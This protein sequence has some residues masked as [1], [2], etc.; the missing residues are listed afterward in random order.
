MNKVFYNKK[1]DFAFFLEVISNRKEFNKEI[2]YRKKNSPYLM[3][4]NEVLDYINFINSF[5][6][7]LSYIEKGF[8]N[9]YFHNSTIFSS[10][11]IYIFFRKL[12]FDEIAFTTFISFIN[13]YYHTTLTGDLS[14]QKIEE[15][16]KKK[17][18][19]I[20]SKDDIN[21][22]AD[23]IIS[24]FR[25]DD[26]IKIFS[27]N[28][29]KLYDKFARILLQ[30]SDDIKAKIENIKSIFIKEYNDYLKYL[31]NFF[32]VDN[33]E[34]YRLVYSYFCPYQKSILERYRCIVI[35]DSINNAKS[36]NLENS[37]ILLNKF[38]SQEK[39]YKII[40]MLSD[41]KYFSTE[42]AKELKITTATMNYHIN[43]LYDL[44]LINIEEG[45]KNRLY[46]DLNK[47]RLCYLLDGMRKDLNI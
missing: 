27:T 37:Y 5:Y 18:I 8:L 6:N 47:N 28:I 7:D 24:I 15:I 3:N 12:S 44:G 41:K 9:T 42:L 43:K 35:G 11:L 16:V 21:K 32:N 22:N 31:N 29:K 34:S 30:Y 36:E 26:N 13:D 2:T 38:L 33:I 14:N 25:D 45:E 1:I 17:S 23:L 19:E 4:D 40:K 20:N 46:I 39:R 10:Y